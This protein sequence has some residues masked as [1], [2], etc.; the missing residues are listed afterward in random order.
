MIDPDRTTTASASAPAGVLPRAQHSRSLF[1]SDLH[2]GAKS[3][4]PAMVLDFLRRNTADTIYLVGD[5]FDTWAPMKPN[6]TPAHDAVVQT[7]LDRAQNGTRVIYLPGNH[8]TMF[9]QYCGLY[10]GIVEVSEQVVHITASG[11]QLLVLHGDVADSIFKRYQW[12]GRLGA[13]LDSQLRRVEILINRVRAR[14]DLP[15]RNAISHAIARFNALI[16]MGNRF[17]ARLVDMARD[18]GHDGV[19]CGHFHK[20]AL[21]QKFGLVYAN[22][23][24][25]VENFTALAEDME[26]NL[27]LLGTAS[28]VKRIARPALAGSADDAVSVHS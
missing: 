11:Q 26:G 14:R 1:L 15:P 10:F 12:I 2:L 8:D 7:L 19:V 13:A 24:D 5:I 22:C 4:R 23:G 3:A 16:R 9:R 17:E 28:C 18:R 6:W 25:W 21:H 20:P 27:L